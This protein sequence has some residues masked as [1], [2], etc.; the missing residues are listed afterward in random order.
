MKCHLSDVVLALEAL[1][2]L[3]AGW[4]TVDACAGVLQDLAAVLLRMRWSPV[5][6]AAVLL[7]QVD[8]MRAVN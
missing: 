8:V 2:G 4:H 5:G 7:I 3:A 1:Q 6:L